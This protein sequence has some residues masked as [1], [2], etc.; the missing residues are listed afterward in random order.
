MTRRDGQTAAAGDGGLAE[1]NRSGQARRRLAARG[2][3]CQ[4]NPR[5]RAEALE[6]Q[7]ELDTLGLE[8]L[9]APDQ[10][11]ESALE[12]DLCRPFVAC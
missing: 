2:P 7:V 3:A 4:T 8:D 9:L 6:Q 12:S 11:S 5:Q 10:R 1:A